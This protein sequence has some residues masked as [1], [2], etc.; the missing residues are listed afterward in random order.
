MTIKSFFIKL[1]ITIA[2]MEGLITLLILLVAAHYFI[3]F[4]NFVQGF[5]ND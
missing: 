3:P 1:L 2:K 4:H 5:I